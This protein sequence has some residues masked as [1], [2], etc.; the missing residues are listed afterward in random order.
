MSPVRNLLYYLLVHFFF[1]CEVRGAEKT[2]QKSYFWATRVHSNIHG[3]FSSK[4]HF[5]GSKFNAAS[6]F[7]AKLLAA[8]TTRTLFIPTASRELSPFIPHTHK[9]AHHATNCCSA[10]QKSSS[11]TINIQNGR[12]NPRTQSNCL[13]ALSLG[14]RSLCV[15]AY[16]VRR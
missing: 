8:R 2:Q 1:C 7:L 4:L 11:T 12:N 13:Y 3:A 9:N 5:N 6:R 14:P 15:A 16:S 10:S